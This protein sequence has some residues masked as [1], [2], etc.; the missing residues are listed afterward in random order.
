MLA[1]AQAAHEIRADL[2]LEQIFDLIVAIAKIHGDAGY[3]D[4][5]LQTMLDGF[6]PPAG[7]PVSRRP[8]SARSQAR[9]HS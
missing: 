6:R 8:G 3:L 2:T 5:M 4:P 1:A 7:G 9:E